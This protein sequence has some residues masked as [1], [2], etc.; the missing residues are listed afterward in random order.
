MNGVPGATE[1]RVSRVIE[2]LVEGVPG[3]VASDN[4][5]A[6]LAMLARCIPGR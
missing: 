4:V 2:V 5:R 1:V 6:V 3:A